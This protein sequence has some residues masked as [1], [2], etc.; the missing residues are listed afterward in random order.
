M[1][2]LLIVFSLMLGAC[3]GAAAPAAPACGADCWL[4]PVSASISASAAP[5]PTRTSTCDIMDLIPNR[6][7]QRDTDV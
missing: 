6:L 5:A 3:G 1:I 7:R 2:S 4:Q